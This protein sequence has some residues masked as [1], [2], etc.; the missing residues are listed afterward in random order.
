MNNHRQ[1][2]A[3]RSVLYGVIVF[4]V[5]LAIPIDAERDPADRATS[6]DQAPVTIKFF[7]LHLRDFA[8][9]PW[10]MVPFGGWRF[11]VA[12]RSVEPQK[13]VWD[14]K[15][16]DAKIDA[17]TQHG[18][19]VIIGLGFPPPWASS[20]PDKACGVGIGEC[21]EPRD[22]QDWRD[23]VSMLGN[24]YKGRV[25]Y[26]EM[27]NE[28]NDPKFY[29]G[30][31]LGLVKVTNAAYEV[32]KKIDPEIQ[33]LSPAPTGRHGIAVLNDF[34]ASGGAKYIDVVAYHFYV[35]PGPPEGVYRYVGELR[36]VM[37]NY[38]IGQ[39][40]IWDTENGWVQIPLDA[41]TQAAYAARTTILDRAAGASR[42]FWYQWGNC[43]TETLCFTEA[44]RRVPSAAG[45]AMQ[46]LQDWMIG[47]V[48]ESCDSTDKPEPKGFSHALWTC[49]LL[50]NGLR[51]YVVWNPDG[52]REF[53]VPDKW[54]IRINRT[55]NLSGGSSP[56]P[57]PRKV[58]VGIQP[59]LLDHGQ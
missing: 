21:A 55:R 8:K 24:R 14:L 54:G 7:G 44:D 35:C 23:Y 38:G 28:P 37:N 1:K 47:A 22:M 11:S 31:I 18:V 33:I 15:D 52:D 25:K 43:Q 6:P 41:N 53:T 16:V 3:V 36:A 20:T 5:V 13:G 50:R 57:N 40:P 32:L 59:L 29:T 48:V 56:L 12:W 45:N 42:I 19:D 46:V 17:A 10:P 4:L 30:T 26:Y 51:D 2:L 9:D 49:A 34:F 58:V 27:W 39:L